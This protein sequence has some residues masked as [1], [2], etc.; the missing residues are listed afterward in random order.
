MVSTGCCWVLRVTRSGLSDACRFGVSVAGGGE[1]HPVLGDVPQPAPTSADCGECADGL[2]RGRHHAGAVVGAVQT[3]RGELG[4]HQVAHDVGINGLRLGP[5]IGVCRP[6]GLT[7]SRAAGK[8][9][10]AVAG[11]GRGQ[12][13]RCSDL[14]CL[15]RETPGT[16]LTEDLGDRGGDR[17][18][19]DHLARVRGGQSPKTTWSGSAGHPPRPG[20]PAS[21]VANSMDSLSAVH[22]GP[23]TS[24][25]W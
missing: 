14:H 19:N 5:A 20:M 2:V 10:G 11:R 3:C 9:A 6:G 17:G 23:A 1:V 21:G 22:P 4:E 18:V 16:K 15:D 7:A 13:G 8:R 24:R 12:P 25:S